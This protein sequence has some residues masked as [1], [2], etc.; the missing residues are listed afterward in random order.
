MRLAVV[1]CDVMSEGVITPR[2]SIGKAY[3]ALD[4]APTCSGPAKNLT[5]GVPIKDSLYK[6]L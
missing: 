1:M 5:R 4:S 3:P 2:G 6:T